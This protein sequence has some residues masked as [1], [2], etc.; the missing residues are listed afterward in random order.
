MKINFISC[1][2][3][4][5]HNTKKQHFQNSKLLNVSIQDTVSFGMM[6]KSAFKGIDLGVVNRYKAPIEK[7]NSNEDFQKWCFEKRKKDY[8]LLSFYMALDEVA[9]EDR[10]EI[11]ETWNK[12]LNKEKTSYTESQKLLISEG[13][14]KDLKP[15]NTNLPPHLDKTILKNTMDEL[16]EIYLKDKNSNVSFHEN[17]IK[18]LKA[19]YIKDLKA[20][21]NG[22]KSGWIIIPKTGY[23]DK[24]Y[25]ESLKK[26]QLFSYK[27]WCTKSHR[28]GSYITKGPI[29]IYLDKEKPKI[30][31]RYDGDEI[32]EIQS[33]KNT[34]DISDK[35]I[36]ILLEHIKG[37]KLSFETAMVK[38]AYEDK[39][40]KMAKLPQ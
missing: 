34:P 2:Q 1:N 31:V 36:P 35:H 8:D 7:F 28:A 16:E 38:R 6:K 5:F 14:V 18:N 27:T 29:H 30:A 33:E 11:L 13:V 21:K 37:D 23:W 22:K 32:V 4:I 26:L 39:L 10:G 3:P 12:Y 40:L 17:Y 19:P 9:T 25:D 24:N 15:T 20:D